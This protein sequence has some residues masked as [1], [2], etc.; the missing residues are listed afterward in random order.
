[1]LRR[2]S[3]VLALCA[4]SSIARGD[5]VRLA[6]GDSLNGDIVEWALDYVVIEHPQLGLVRL[7]LEELA[8][9]M[10]KPPNPGLFGTNFLRG[11]NRG[12]DIGWNGEEGSSETRNLILGLDFNY[13]DAFKRWSIKG[14]YFLDA[15]EDGTNDNYARIDL[16]RDW[17][18]P[19]LPWFAFVSSRYQYDEFE[20]WE[21]RSTLTSGPGYHLV[22]RE[23]HKLDTR[24]GVAFTREFGERN[25]DKFESLFALDYYWQPAERYSF[26]ISNQLFTQTQPD[27]GEIRNLTTGEMKILLSERPALNLKIGAENDY[28]TDIEDDDNNNDLKYYIAFGIDF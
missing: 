26:S 18:F 27:F 4:C 3:M 15:D 7:S 23:A 1:M 16:R 17:L 2:I 28:E 5:T 19:G 6:N 21:H 8:V 11:W 9:D 22:S 10:G 12:I 20:S 24:L 25:D 14:R 13:A